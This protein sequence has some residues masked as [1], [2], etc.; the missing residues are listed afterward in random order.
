MSL[1]ES[2]QKNIIET[3]VGRLLNRFKIKSRRNVLFFEDI[4]AN[5]VKECEE[6]GHEEEIKEVAQKWCVLTTKQLV[7]KNLKKLPFSLLFPFLKRMWINLGLMDD[8]NVIKSKDIIKIETKNE[9]VTR[10]IGKNKCLIGFYNGILSTLFNSQIECIEAL[11]TKEYCN[12]VYK[13]KDERFRIIKSKEKEVYDKLNQLPKLKGTTLK[14]ALKANL[15]QLKNNRVY[16]RGKPMWYVENTGF[17]ILSNRGILLERIP[18]ISYNFFK[19]IIKKNSSDT[20]K[21]NLL[22]TLLQSMGWGIVRIINKNDRILFE[23]NYLPYG[24]QSEK[25]NWSLLTNLICGYL[26]LIDENFKVENIKEFYKKLVITY[27][28]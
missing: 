10:I 18:P 20:G 16:F 23:I 8:L 27:S 24:L 3:T 26:W 17:H 14:D 1:S 6:T 13:I 15:F 28:S 25:D 21:L 7:P 22:K 11:Q 19:Q 9:G 2:L 5:Y 12:Y 4:L